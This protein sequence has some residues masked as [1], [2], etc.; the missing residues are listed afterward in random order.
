MDYKPF[1]PLDHNWPIPIAQIAT[2]IFLYMNSAKLI[3]KTDYELKGNAYGTSS[4]VTVMLF[5]YYVQRYLRAQEVCE[6]CC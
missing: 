6:K 1:N 5:N 4:C 3:V 2:I